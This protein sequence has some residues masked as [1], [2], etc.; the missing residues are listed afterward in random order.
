MVEIDGERTVITNRSCMKELDEAIDKEAGVG[1]G[2]FLLYL[3]QLAGYPI[4][5]YAL[6]ELGRVYACS[7]GGGRP[8]LLYIQTT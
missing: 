5:E 4:P 1:L 3:A 6:R 7:E 8:L 2:R